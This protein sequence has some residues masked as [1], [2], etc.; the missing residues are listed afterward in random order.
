MTEPLSAA[1]RPG[2][3]RRATRTFGATPDRLAGRW[4][5]TDQLTGPATR[6]APAD[7]G[8]ADPAAAAEF[9]PSDEP[10]PPVGIE[11]NAA[12]AAQP[13]LAPERTATFT[14]RMA[15]I[16]AHFTNS[17]TGETSV[18]RPLVTIDAH[19]LNVETAAPAQRQHPSAP[20]LR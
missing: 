6:Q 20:R 15:A 11:V 7:R 1:A 3:R 4:P 13:D 17:S 14:E 8:E 16:N 19:E 5:A 2:R 12:D 9:Q 18:D 10:A